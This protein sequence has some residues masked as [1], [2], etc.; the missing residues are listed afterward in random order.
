[1]SGLDEDFYAEVSYKGELW[2]NG[3][4]SWD[5]DDDDETQIRVTLYVPN[6]FS[7]ESK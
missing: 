5:W 2:Y 4:V 6:P 1:M 3:P 7:E